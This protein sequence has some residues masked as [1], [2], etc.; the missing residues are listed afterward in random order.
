MKNTRYEGYRGPRLPSKV[1]HERLLYVMKHELTE[2]QRR[3][4]ED[5][6]INGKK[7]P[8]MAAEYGVNKSTVCRT[9]HRGLTRLR[10]YLRY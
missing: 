6:Y 4:I 1:Q 7:M 3:A 5:Y 2:K 8:E 10:R 9:L